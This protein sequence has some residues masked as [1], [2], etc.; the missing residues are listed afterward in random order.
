M[1]KYA[2]TKA[3]LF[4]SGRTLN[5]PKT[6]NWFLPPNAFQY[7]DR[8][9]YDKIPFIQKLFAKKL[10]LRYLSKN[11]FVRTEAEEFGLFTAYY[12]YLAKKLPS[13]AADRSIIENLAKDTVYN[14]DKFVFY[15][16]VRA[17]LSKLKKRYTLGILSDTWPSLSRAYKNFGIFDCFSCFVMSCDVGACKPDPRMYLKALA[18]LP[19][20]ST[21][22]LFVD[23]SL[24][25]LRGAEKLGMLPVQICR[26]KQ[27][28]G[29][30]PHI[31]N[32]YELLKLLEL[33]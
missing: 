8:E 21:Q 7:I 20:S 11:Q 9:K 1:Q 14:D 18:E 10:A 13:L 22:I 19:F 30:Y 17:V 26:E 23:D 12:E 16:D 25:N 6:G 15:D 33:R 4:D 24:K 27:R 5:Y 32:L 2:N 29:R 28:T 3:I 31:S